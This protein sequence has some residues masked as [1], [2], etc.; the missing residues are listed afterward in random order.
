MGDETQGAG[1][2]PVSKRAVPRMSEAALATLLRDICDGRVFTSEQ[3]PDM[4]QLPMV[5][6]PILFGGLADVDLT[7]LGILCA[8]TETAMPWS[9]NGLP[10]FSSMRL[11]HKDDWERIRPTIVAEMARRRTLVPAPL[12]SDD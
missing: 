3:V 12:A 4:D 7:T 10:V 9:I 1:D 8:E 5:F 2:A 11:V 6:L